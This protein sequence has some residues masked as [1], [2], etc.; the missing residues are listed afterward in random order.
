MQQVNDRLAHRIGKCVIRLVD[1]SGVAVADQEVRIRQINHSFLFGAGIFDVVPFVNQSVPQEKLTF[2]E[3]EIS[4]FLEVFNFATLPFYWGRF[5]PEQGKPQTEAL[6]RAAEWLQQKGVIVKGHPLCWHTVTAPWLL[7]M[8][9]EQI[10]RAQLS[11]IEREVS[12]FEGVID[13]WDVINEVV[14]MPIFDKYDNGI[15]RICK[16]LGRIELIKQV[17]AVAKAANP[18]ATLLLNDFNTTTNYEIL[19]DGCLHAG[20]PIDAIG[21]QSHQHQGYWGREKVEEVL[22]R[23]SHFGVPIHFTENTLTSGHLM[24]PEIEDLNDYQ[25]AEWP[26]T[27]E[28]EE[29]QAREVEEM[30]TIL[31]EHPQVQAIT[32]WSFSDH[33][34]WLGA[35]A[36][37][38][39]K[40]NG[41]KPSYDVLKRLITKDWHT[42][43]VMKTD[44]N[45]VALVEGFLGDYELVCQDKVSR[46]RLTGNDGQLDLVM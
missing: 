17:F 8:S 38:I 44:G 36:G 35:P 39:R 21:I 33:G 13:M 6:S 40:D 18:G 43:C 15:T 9:N 34:A 1:G 25:I 46:F 22:E 19:I 28:Y 5:E 16:E 24:P 7:D 3:E 26:S 23:F 29:R 12:N 27:P 4:R 30:Y 10:L 2:L 14:I 41:P 42:E 31:F 11:R 20:V 32:S 37:L 45:G